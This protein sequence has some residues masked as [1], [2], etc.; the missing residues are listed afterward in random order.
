MFVM[1][2]ETSDGPPKRLCPT[3]GET[4]V[5]IL[6]SLA[7]DWKKTRAWHANDGSLK[8]GPTL[9]KFELFKTSSETS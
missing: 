3:S 9:F 2:G 1:A 7:C 6:S 4:D 5:F 8:T